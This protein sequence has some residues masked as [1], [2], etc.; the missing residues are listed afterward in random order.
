MK[1]WLYKLAELYQKAG[2]EEDCVRICDKLM[3]LFGLG[4]YVDKAMALKQKYAPFNQI[5]DG[6]GGKAEKSMRKML[7]AVEEEYS[8]GRR[9]RED[10]EI[11][12]DEDFDEP[13][14]DSEA[15][16]ARRMAVGASLRGGAG[17][18]RAGPGDLQN[19]PGRVPCRR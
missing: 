8:S 14:D 19:S 10:E 11:E 17:R 2:R 3:L 15:E 6:S 1:K 4:K 18:E 9:H 7:R 13:D 5:S 16:E 12:A